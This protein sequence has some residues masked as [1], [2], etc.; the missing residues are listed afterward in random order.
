MLRQAIA[1]AVELAGNE[2]GRV[3]TRRAK[4]TVGR[5]DE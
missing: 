1:A 2:A 5:Q 4:M 3:A